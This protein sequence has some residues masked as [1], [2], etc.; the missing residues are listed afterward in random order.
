MDNTEFVLGSNK[1]YK[2]VPDKNS[3]SFTYDCSLNWFP[4]YV[5]TNRLAWEIVLGLTMN[6]K[7]LVS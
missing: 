7:V 3:L 2:L 5:Q 4:F 6:G 1:T